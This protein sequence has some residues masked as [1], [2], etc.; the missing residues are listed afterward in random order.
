MRL[1]RRFTTQL[2]ARLDTGEIVAAAPRLHPMAFCCSKKV[3]N[4]GF[5]FLTG[6]APTAAVEDLEAGIPARIASERIEIRKQPL[7]D[8]TP[9]LRERARVA[10]TACQGYRVCDTRGLGP[11][12]CE[13]SGGPGRNTAACVVSGRAHPLSSREGL[14]MQ[15]FP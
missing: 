9:T 12:L 2:P 10:G 3:A 7:L 4:L 1:P 11:T 5:I 15:G 8:R 13:S 14:R 6:A